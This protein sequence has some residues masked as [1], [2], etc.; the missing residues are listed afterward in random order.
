M[1]DLLRQIQAQLHRERHP[2]CPHCKGEIDMTDSERVS[3]HV[4]YWGEDDPVEEN[5][6][7]CNV[8]IY[9]AEHVT[10]RWTVGRTP[11]EAADL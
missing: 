5:C 8:T 9:L 11:E 3:G 10:R 4:S 1:S 7:N 2:I 6:P